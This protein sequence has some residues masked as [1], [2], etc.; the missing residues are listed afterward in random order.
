MVTKASPSFI[1][2]VPTAAAALSAAP[3]ATAVPAHSP[4]SSATSGDIPPAFSQDS[5]IVGSRDMSRPRASAISLDHFL[6]FT[7]N[8]C[9]PE[10]SDASV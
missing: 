7:F 1:V 8:N 9:V 4:V 3:A 2:Y 6:S 10:A 5:R